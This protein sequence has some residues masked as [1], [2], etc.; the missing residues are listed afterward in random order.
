MGRWITRRKPG[1]LPF[2]LCNKLSGKKVW[3]WVNSMLFSQFIKTIIN[4]LKLLYLKENHPCYKR[5]NAS[6]FKWSIKGVFFRLYHKNAMLI[7]F[8]QCCNY[9]LYL[10]FWVP[11][12]FFL[13][14]EGVNPPPPS[15]HGGDALPFFQRILRRFHFFRTWINEHI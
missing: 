11:L 7:I 2:S 15:S 6:I 14:K 4:R 9:Q 8:G 13:L 1:D 10:Y 5:L 12:T 3:V